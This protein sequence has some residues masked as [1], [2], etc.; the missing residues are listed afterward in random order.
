MFDWRDWLGIKYLYGRR[1]GFG[2]V[3]PELMVVV[4]V[5]AIL[6]GVWE[7]ATDSTAGVTQSAL[8]LFLGVSAYIT[9]VSTQALYVR[10]LFESRRY[11]GTVDRH[12]PSR[13]ETSAARVEL[14]P[15]VRTGL[16]REGGPWKIY[17]A[18]FGDSVSMESYYTVF[19]AQLRREVPQLVLDSRQAK[20]QQFAKVYLHAQR[21]EL[22]PNLVD[23]FEV[24]APNGYQ[25]E[26]LSFIT[27]EVIEALMLMADRDVE[28]N[29]DS[30]LCYAPLLS[31]A[32]LD[33]FQSQCLYL[34]NK[35]ADNLSPNPD[36]RRARQSPPVRIA[37]DLGKRLLKNP[38]RCQRWLQL[39]GWATVAVLL[40]AM[41]TGSTLVLAFPVSSLV[42]SVFIALLVDRTLTR[43]KNRHQEAVLRSLAGRRWD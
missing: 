16:I 31:A 13:I 2:R 1:H 10:R 38:Y 41:M 23:Y 40:I 30:L 27:P 17:D 34:Y 11:S 5:L 22:G 15:L 39:T 20:R 43:R 42:I 32:D 37:T 19:E 35:V 18:V 28:F 24:Y 36:R 3:L 25:I 9:W 7:E 29:R 4:L 12:S 14:G 6:G 33:R 8:V 26:A 21:L